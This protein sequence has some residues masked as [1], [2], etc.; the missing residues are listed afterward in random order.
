MQQDQLK[1][2]YFCM[3][4][5]LQ[6]STATSLHT[7]SYEMRQRCAGQLMAGM[8]RVGKLT[9]FVGLDGFVDEILHVVDKRENA[10]KFTRLPTIT[11]FAERLAGAAGR[12]TN[13]ELVCT[14]TKLGGN[15]PLMANALAPF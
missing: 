10:E 14:L 6:H 9:A 13:V 15:G 12:S 5:T 1:A 11:K 8:E 2:L 3:S 4:S 7:A